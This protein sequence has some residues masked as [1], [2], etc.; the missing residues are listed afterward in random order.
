M[1]T[2]YLLPASHKRVKQLA[3]DLDL[4]VHELLLHGQRRG[5]A[6]GLFAPGP[7]PIQAFGPLARWTRAEVMAR[8]AHHGITLPRQYDEG[9]PETVE[10][11]VCP[12][13][14][15]PAWLAFL[16]QHYPDAHAETL[17]LALVAWDRVEQTGKAIAHQLR[18][19]EAAVE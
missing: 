19:A 2:V 16:R 10:C 7:Q 11:A 6:S 5:E 12:S 14:L 9:F 8:V 3:L 15:T 13:N 18:E 4:T 1:G 17:R